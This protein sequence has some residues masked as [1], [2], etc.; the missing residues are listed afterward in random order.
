MVPRS[1]RKGDGLVFTSFCK[2]WKDIVDELLISSVERGE[3]L[4]RYWRLKKIFL[5]DIGSR[6]SCSGKCG[7][8]QICPAPSPRT[9]PAMMRILESRPLLCIL[10]T[11]K[12]VV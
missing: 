9:A 6:D 1:S 12:Q 5:A 8:E 11:F 3:V 7:T 4:G 2:P 10:V